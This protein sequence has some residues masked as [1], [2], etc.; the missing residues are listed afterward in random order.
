ME[1]KHHGVKG[2]KWG[3]RRYQNYDGSRI[4]NASDRTLRKSTKFTRY[5]NK[6][7]TDVRSGEYVSFKKSDVNEYKLD[8]ILGQLGFKGAEHIF[9]KSIENVEPIVIRNGKD[10][11]NDIVSK[12]R[13]N[14]IKQ[15][16]KLLNEKRYF[17][18][19]TDIFK[20]KKLIMNS[21]DVAD[22]RA[23][24]ANYIHK[25]VYKNRNDFIKKYKDLGYDAIVDPEDLTWNYDTPLIIA[26]PSKFKIT[27]NKEI[28]S[29]EKEKII[30]KFN[31][32]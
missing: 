30:K 3:V 19:D 9:T 4:R 25:H 32:E 17:D 31:K 8:A 21:D 2:Q 10:V 13:N 28:S 1:L 23:D 29:D 27:K 7:E 20:R 5:S 12:T 22:A 26:D 18:D 15:S 6:K 24:V 14:S 11:V 16:Y